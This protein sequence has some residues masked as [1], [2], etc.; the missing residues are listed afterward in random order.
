[1]PRHRPPA[2]GPNVFPV[3]PD[4]QYFALPVIGLDGE[5]RYLRVRWPRITAI[6]SRT[7]WPPPAEIRLLS[8]MPVVRRPFVECPYKLST[9]AEDDARVAELVRAEGEK[10]RKGAAA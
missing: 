8:E 9:D 2:S 4:R 10:T 1:M 6:P 7:P 3:E 5:R